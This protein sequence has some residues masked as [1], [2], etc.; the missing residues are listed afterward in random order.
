MTDTITFEV[1]GTGLVHMIG[2]G[3]W[4]VVEIGHSREIKDADGKI[5]NPTVVQKFSG[6]ALKPNRNVVFAKPST[7][8]EIVRLAN[9]KLAEVTA[10]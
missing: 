3:P 4:R 8:N 9:E 10:G 6:T 5:A 1:A 2:R 7:A